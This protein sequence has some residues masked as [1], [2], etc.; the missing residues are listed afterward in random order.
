M[1]GDGPATMDAPS[2]SATS[3][4]AAAFATLL[5]GGLPGAAAAEAP[6]AALWQYRVP[7]ERGA[8][9][10]GKG[11]APGELLFW[12][13]PVRGTLRGLLIL[14]QLG[15]EGELVSSPEVR[16]ACADAAT[17]I[18]YFVPHISG[19]FHYWEERNTDR[20][21]LLDAL[22][23]LALRVGHPEIRRVPWIT[24]GHSTAGI[25]A[26]NVAFWQPERVAGVIH[27][28]SGNFWQREHLPPGASLG[29][30]P[31]VALNGQFET[32]GP[33][34]GIRPEWGRQTQ[35]V[36]ALRDI[37]R[38]RAADPEHLMS[39]WVHHGDDH[40]FGAPELERFVALFIRKCARLRLPATLP[41][42]DAPVRCLPVKAEQGWLADPNLYAPEHAPAPFA[43]YAGDRAKA[44]WHLD[45]EMA[46]ATAE[47]HEKLGRH[48]CL[49]IPE[50]AFGV[51]GD[52]WSFR[53]SSR[54]LDRMP[55]DYGG[56]VAN[57]AIGHSKAPFVLRA[58]AGEP[59]ARMGP[60]TF[61]LLRTP[62][63]RKPAVHI[64]AFHPGDEGFRSTI[65]WGALEIPQVGGAAQA[66]GSDEFKD[67]LSLAQA[68][69]NFPLAVKPAAPDDTL[70]HVWEA[71]GRGF[72]AFRNN[73]S[74]GPDSIVAQIYARDGRNCGWSQ[75]EAGCF[76]LYGLG[77]EWAR[78]LN[79]AAGKTGSRWHD[80]VV[81]LPEDPVNPDGRGRVV[82]FEADDRT[83]SG[84]VAF[85]M[86][87][88]YECFRE[89]GEGNE[90]RRELFD[91]GIR[92]VRA[93]AADFGGKSGAPALFA[94]ADRIAGGAKKVWAM[95][96][97]PADRDGPDYRLEIGGNAFAI[98]YKDASM[99]AT[100]AS[101][102]GVRIARAQGRMKAHP[103]SGITDVEVDA[104]H[105]M[106]E[107][108]ADG[109]FLVVI[110]LQ[111]S[112]PPDVRGSG[113]RAQVG[114][115]TVTFDGK[116][117]RIE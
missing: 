59:V 40:F 100:F 54:W 28:K 89:V 111:R 32:F 107:D 114:A 17:A 52:G 45:R 68:F 93:F 60:D 96:L 51:E 41:P 29:G 102:R 70:P 44:L 1:E 66:F 42:G 27:V 78:K 76:Q 25:F 10:R 83:G 88:A 91:A 109:D 62:A 72:Y 43:E 18:A 37:Q 64:A 85:D 97:P 65:R 63:G 26:R 115:R 80:N 71:K 56:E 79:D 39:L 23:D 73:W 86:S 74:D 98:V 106:G 95:Q 47:W 69:I 4:R 19:V 82:S 46:E 94:I 31:L 104:I 6:E 103:L 8:D 99:K 81:M 113:G 67:G 55:E 24:A 105:A 57:E 12:M 92:G 58:R 7:Y 116:R 90:K 87:R 30:V 84:S 33:E 9:S 22:D 75:A 14:G 110:T 50:M 16:R 61:L 38:F 101:P 117:L 112:D 53:V 35:W 2:P 11:G 13:P 49:E 5:P 3:I 36:C 77:H 48:Q 20:Q 15:I 108:P 21:R 34:G